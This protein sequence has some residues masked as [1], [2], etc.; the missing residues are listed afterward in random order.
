M[1]KRYPRVLRVVA[2]HP[3]AILP[4]TLDSIVEMLELRAAGQ[5]FTDEEIRARIG[6]RAARA[7]PAAQGGPV[8]VIPLVGV[9]APH[10]DLMTE[11]SGGTSVGAFTNAV[12]AAVADPEV[13]AVVLNVSSPLLPFDHCRLISTPSFLEGGIV[14]DRKPNFIPSIVPS[15]STV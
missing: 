8:A 1:A 15:C 13:A 9:I 12:R 2:A 14:D 4:A 11:I 5:M 10:M 7:A 6:A 3:W